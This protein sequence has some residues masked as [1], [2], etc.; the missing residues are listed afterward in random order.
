MIREYIR[1]VIIVILAVALTVALLVEAETTQAQAA[2]D[3][4]AAPL[5]IED[6][7]PVIRYAPVRYSVSPAPTLETTPEPDPEPEP[8]PEPT[9]EPERYTQED[10][11]LIARVVHAESRGETFEGQVAVAAVVLNRYESGRFGRSV[12]NVVFA[13]NQF[14]IKKRYNSQNMRAV[15]AAIEGTEHP[16]DMFYFR[17]SKKKKWRNFEY[18]YRVGNHSFYAAKRDKPQE[19]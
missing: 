12:K 9:P 16:E 2:P 10:K 14:S 1:A 18:L 5:A 13:R 17:V 6:A 8:T 11:V 7:E 15:E 3:E 4:E 19:P